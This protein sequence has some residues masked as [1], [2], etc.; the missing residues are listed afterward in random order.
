MRIK[1]ETLIPLVNTVIKSTKISEAS[2][3]RVVAPVEREN[4][5][6]NENILRPKT[7]SE[8]IGQESIKKH[9]NIAIK[10]AQIRKVPLEHILLYGPPG[11][12]KTT[13]SA[14]IAS[15]MQSHLKQTSGP[16]IEK[17]ADIVS[18]L[19]SLQEWDVLFIDEIHR[20]RPQIEEILYSAMEDFAIDIMI[21]TGTGATSIRMDIPRFTLV[22]ATTKL[23]KISW[24]LRDRFGNVLKLD[25]Y[26][27]A[28]LS[29]IVRRSF[30]ILGMTVTNSTIWE[31]VARKSRGTP[32][33]VNRFV[34]TL[35]DYSIV[36]HDIDDT[37]EAEKIF[38]LLGIDALGLDE[39]DRK[40][41]ETLAYSFPGRTVG[42]HTLAS[43]V[44]E[45]EETLEDV[46]EPYLL[47]I[48][49]LER[50]PR[51]RKLS[52]SGEAYI[53]LGK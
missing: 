3:T 52:E 34:K 40:L 14:I 9:L 29:E 26:E 42:L 1:E 32:R 33:I 31:L 46:V 6:L 12:G 37:L 47:K 7:L 16:A 8:Y 22:G 18:L 45:E 43:I 21:G 27:I 53:R 17:Q 2:P 15:E 23:A 11:L 20:L 10:S 48:G 44:W 51:G 24:P 35:R 5:S 28:D 36:G 19:T 38:T 25:F 49:F 4:D 41:L 30:H 39:L 50:T 13:L